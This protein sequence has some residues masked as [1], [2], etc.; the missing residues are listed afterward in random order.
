MQA[1]VIATLHPCHRAMLFI[2]D[3]LF[4]IFPSQ[5][6]RH[7]SHTQRMKT[8]GFSFFCNALL[9]FFTH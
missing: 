1:P 9:D 3:P 5:I 4:V 8:E 2:S 6:N 7:R